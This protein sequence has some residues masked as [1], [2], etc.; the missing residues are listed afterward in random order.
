MNYSTA[1]N[2]TLAWEEEK[3]R[4]K[5]IV[6]S[7][8]L[9]AE[10]IQGYDMPLSLALG[11]PEKME[12]RLWDNN[13]SVHQMIF[14]AREKAYSM[15]LNPEKKQSHGFM[16]EFVK[17]LDERF[18]RHDLQKIFAVNHLYNDIFHF[19]H[20]EMLKWNKHYRYESTEY[21]DFV[22]ICNF[23]NLCKYEKNNL[24]FS[25]FK[26]TIS[27]LDYNDIKSFKDY[28]YRLANARYENLF[29]SDKDISTIKSIIESILDERDA[30]ALLSFYGI[31]GHSMTLKEVVSN[32][33]YPDVRWARMDIERAKKKLS[34]NPSLFPAIIQATPWVVDGVVEELRELR[35]DPIFKKERELEDMIRRN[36]RLPFVGKDK[37]IAIANRNETIELLNL[38]DRAYQKLKRAGI[39][40]IEDVAKLDYY[41]LRN[42]LQ[43]ESDYNEIVSK[44]RKY[45]YTD[46]LSR[47]N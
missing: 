41:K 6:T 9:A 32:Y 5:G 40:K 11:V 16:D 22:I 28:G 4:T 42:I 19:D 12:K 39:N 20:Y 44:M 25:E 33:G 46:Y 38:S 2:I 7:S 15:D 26:K 23:Q 13:S 47:E 29:C 1:K 21:C 10:L 30:K 17:A 24:A 43:A 31:C 18:I 3:A 27:G 34:K 37:A 36:C 45:G 8:S 14:K 35:N